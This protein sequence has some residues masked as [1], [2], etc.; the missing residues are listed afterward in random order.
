MS[1]EVYQQ[2]TTDQLMAN[3]RIPS[4]TGYKTVP[5]RNTGKMRNTGWEFHIDTH[6]LIK[7]GK[8]TMD[9]NVNFNNNRNEILEMD[10]YVLSN[11]NSTF[12][13]NNAETLQRVQLHNPLGALYGF[14]Y[15][16]VYQYNYS[17]VQYMTEEERNEFFASGKTAPVV[18]NADGRGGARRTG[19]SPAYDVQLHHRCH[20][21]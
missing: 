18:M 9:M 1:F 13:Y 12:G 21:T 2:T 14:R 8:F 17:T 3:Y 20:W 11:R 19:R 10:E 7:A 16:G 5:Y 15:K 6:R 4:N